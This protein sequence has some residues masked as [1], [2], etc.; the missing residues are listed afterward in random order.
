MARTTLLPGPQAGGHPGGD[1]RS[2]G[3]SHLVIGVGLNLA[4]PSREGEKIDQAWSELR[5]P[6]RAGGSQRA[7]R[8]RAAAPA[9][10]HADLRT[11]GTGEFRREL[12][13]LDHFAGQPVKL[14]MGEQVIRGLPGDRRTRSPASGDGRGA[15]ALS[16]GNS[17]L[18][19]GL[20]R[21]LMRTE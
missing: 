4:M 2:A 1:E 19:R 13:P 15:Q 16:G 21:T 8:L 11:D 9:A 20:T 5:H 12:E 3:A 7:G 10:G 17:P 14:L 18:R 6:A